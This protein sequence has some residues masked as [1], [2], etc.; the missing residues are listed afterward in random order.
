MS[1]FGTPDVL[2]LAD[3]VQL[4]DVK[5]ASYLFAMHLTEGLL[6]SL[7]FSTILLKSLST[8]RPI[9]TLYGLTD[10]LISFLLTSDIGK[11]KEKKLVAASFQ[12]GS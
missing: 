3:G 2:H 12:L 6:R 10:F 5:L 9:F 1:N 8:Y 4:S 7:V 11:C